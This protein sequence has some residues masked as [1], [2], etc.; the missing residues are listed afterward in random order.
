MNISAQDTYPNLARVNRPS[1]KSGKTT[2]RS[3]HLVDWSAVL[4]HRFTAVLNFTSLISFSVKSPIS[5]DL[6][7]YILMLESGLWRS[8]FEL[9]HNPVT[10]IYSQGAAAAK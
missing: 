4:Q 1:L 6:A 7:N 2:T 5:A 3:L 8:G 10:S 9:N